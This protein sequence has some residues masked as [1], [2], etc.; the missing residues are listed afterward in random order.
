MLSII[1]VLF[2][3]AASAAPSIMPFV[4]AA[5]AWVHAV[6]TASAAALGAVYHLYQPTPSTK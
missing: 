2:T 5:P 4:S 6:M 1:T 3:A